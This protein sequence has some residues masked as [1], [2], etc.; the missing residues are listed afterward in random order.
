MV[1]D[2]PRMYEA[3]KS[4]PSTTRN[5]KNVCSKVQKK[6]ALCR[7][8][9][10][11]NLLSQLLNTKPCINNKPRVKLHKLG[12]KNNREHYAEK[13]QEFTKLV[14]ICALFKNV[15]VCV[16]CKYVVCTFVFVCVLVCACV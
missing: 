16:T 6:K 2:S 12:K 9:S 3:F 10:G 11:Q 8:S 7:E 4:I 14:D 13:C 15:C 1:E 5:K